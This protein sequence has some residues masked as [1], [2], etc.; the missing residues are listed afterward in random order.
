M[1]NKIVVG[2]DGS[3]HAKRALDTAIEWAHDA[4]D[5]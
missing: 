3:E 1:A 2:Y 5:E 4:L